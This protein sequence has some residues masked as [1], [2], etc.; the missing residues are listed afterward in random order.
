MTLHDTLIFRAFHL[1]FYSV[2][3][4]RGRVGIKSF[5]ELAGKE[6]EVTEVTEA[7]LHPQFRFNKA[8]VKRMRLSGSTQA[9]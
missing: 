7:Q 3:R 1:F 2:S 6:L 9:M 4:G 5:L 8:A